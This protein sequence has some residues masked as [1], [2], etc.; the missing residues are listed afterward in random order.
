MTR[1]SVRT[2]LRRKRQEKRKKVVANNPFEYGELK[3]YERMFITFGNTIKKEDY[4]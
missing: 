4:E 1:S 3:D 2:E